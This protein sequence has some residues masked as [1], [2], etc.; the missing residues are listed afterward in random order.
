[1]NQG[2]LR[3]NYKLNNRLVSNRDAPNQTIF[4]LF[5]VYLFIL[6]LAFPFRFRY[7]VGPFSSFSPMDIALMLGGI[8]VAYSLLS[9]RSNMGPSSLLVALATPVIFCCLSLVWTIETVSTIKVFVTYSEALV[10]YLVAFTI[11]SNLSSSAIAKSLLIF[12]TVIIATAFLSILGFPGLEVQVPL[13]YPPGTDA[14][15]LYIISFSARLSHPFIGLSNNFATVVAFFPILF[16]AYA[17][18]YNKKI[19]FY[20]ALICFLVVA[21]TLSRGVTGA[22]ILSYFIYIIKG[23]I[24]L[25]GMWSIVLIALILTGGVFLYLELNPVASSHFHGRLGAASVTGRF[26]GW[27]LGLD[28]ISNSPLYGYGAGATIKEGRLYIDNLHNTYL[29]QL[30]YYGWFGGSI[31]IMSI[32]FLPVLVARLRLEGDK[33]IILKRGV[34]FALITELIVFA[35]QASL[36]GS[37]LRVIF[38]FS[39]GATMALV[40]A[41]DREEQAQIQS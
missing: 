27:W 23:K 36:E 16:F 15:D 4:N 8:V 35:S 32:L 9:G 6:V 11:F 14:Y 30:L 28:A 2:H 37:V 25:K 7:A 33:A 12:V 24:F 17:M 10:A 21:L 1:M 41:C 3:E 19:F 39:I 38:Y 13:S 20:A 29:N 22:L 40:F 34:V 18:A 26:T 31:V 5:F